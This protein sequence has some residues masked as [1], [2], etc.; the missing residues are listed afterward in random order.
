MVLQMCGLMVHLIVALIYIMLTAHLLMLT[1][2]LFGDEMKNENVYDK[3]VLNRNLMR[4]VFLSLRI[5]VATLM[6]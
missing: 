4:F 3:I 2:W 1:F 6:A 5:K